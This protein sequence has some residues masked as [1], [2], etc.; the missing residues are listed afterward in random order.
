MNLRKEFQI[1]FQILM[2]PVNLV[3][4]NYQIWFSIQL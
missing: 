2:R 3:I 4:E 1:S